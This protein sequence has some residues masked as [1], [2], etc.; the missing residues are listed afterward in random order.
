MPRSLK[1]GPYIDPKLENKVKEMNRGKIKK[2]IKTIEQRN[3]SLKREASAE[4]KKTIKQKEKE[5][6]NQIKEKV[7]LHQLKMVDIGC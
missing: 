6:Q 5:I 3:D 4:L 1:K 2:V 7:N